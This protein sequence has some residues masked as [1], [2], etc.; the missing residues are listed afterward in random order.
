MKHNA[1]TIHL[2]Q[3]SRNSMNTQTR[4][5]VFVDYTNLLEYKFKKLEKVASRIFVFIEASQ[6]NIPLSLVRQ[7]QN[8]GKNLRWIVVSNATKGKLNYHIAF[9]MGKLHQ[10]LSK[11][12]EFA[13]V[14][15]DVDFD[16]LVSYINDSG[17]SCLRVQ[18]KSEEKVFL[19]TPPNFDGMEEGD[20][21]GLGPLGGGEPIDVL[22]EDEIIGKTAEETVKRLIRSG[23]RPAEVETLKNYINLHFQQMA[24]H[25][26]IDRILQKMQEAKDI[27]IKEEGEVVYNF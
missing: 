15:N 25:G 7:T 18:R 23:N 2:S 17:R 12:V 14:S 4:R 26:H 27:E 9:I 16:A 5:Y 19:G 20:Y 3:N 11:D 24:L 6:E 22:V 21:N 8:A 10:K 13:V 1:H